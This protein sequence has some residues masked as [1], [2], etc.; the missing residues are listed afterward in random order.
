M[1]KYKINS[2]PDLANHKR[3]RT[4][5]KKLVEANNQIEKLK[6]ELQLVKKSKRKTEEGQVRGQGTERECF[7]TA[8]RDSKS[9]NK[10]LNKYDSEHAKDSNMVSIG[11]CKC[12][13]T[14]K[15][16]VQRN[17]R[18]EEEN[19]DPSFNIN[20]KHSLDPLTNEE[21][22]ISAKVEH[23]E[24]LPE[25]K[26]L[27][28]E[29]AFDMVVKKL[30][31]L[32]RQ[33]FFESTSQ[34]SKA[35]TYYDRTEEI[36]VILQ[37][38]ESKEKY[39]GHRTFKPAFSTLKEKSDMISTASEI[40]NAPKTETRESTGE[41]QGIK[42]TNSTDQE[43][44]K[45]VCNG[46]MVSSHGAS[47]DFEKHYSSKDFSSKEFTEDS[48]ETEKYIPGSKFY[49]KIDLPKK[50]EIRR[51]TEWD[52]HN[53]ND[54][55]NSIK[56]I[57]ESTRI[58][59][60]CSHPDKDSIILQEEK[61][62]KITDT[63]DPFDNLRPE[64]FSKHQ[65][66]CNFL[67]G[68]G[69]EKQYS[70]KDY[71]ATELI[72]NDTL[73]TKKY[74]PAT[75]FYSRTDTPKKRENRRKT[76]LDSSDLNDLK[77]LIKDISESISMSE[78][79]DRVIDTDYPVHKL[80]SE[81]S[82]HQDSHNLIEDPIPQ[83]DETADLSCDDLISR[84]LSELQTTRSPEQFPADIEEKE[85][86][87]ES[88][89]EGLT[90]KLSGIRQKERNAQELSG[91]VP[92][93]KFYSR[94]D[95]PKK[96]EVRRKTEL[97]SQVL[98]NLK[99]FKN[100]AESTGISE[101]YSHPHEDSI[102]SQEQ[103]GSIVEENL[104]Y[105]FDSLVSE[106]LS[107]QLQDSYDLLEDPNNQQDENA[108]KSAD[109]SWDDLIS[110]TLSE[111]QTTL[112]PEQVSICAKEKTIPKAIT[113]ERVD[114]GK[115]ATSSRIKLEEGKGQIKSD[116]VVIYPKRSRKQKTIPIR[117]I[118]TKSGN[119]EKAM[120]GPSEEYSKKMEAYHALDKD[121]KDEFKNKNM[122]DQEKFQLS[123]KDTSSFDLEDHINDGKICK[124]GSRTEHMKNIYDKKLLAEKLRDGT[125]EIM[126]TTSNT[127]HDNRDDEL[128][129]QEW[130]QLGV[131][132]SVSWDNSDNNAQSYEKGSSASGER[133]YEEP[134]EDEWNYSDE[135]NEIDLNTG[136]LKHHSERNSS[137]PSEIAIKNKNGQGQRNGKTHKT[138]QTRKQSSTSSGEIPRESNAKSKE[139][140]YSIENGEHVE[141]LSEKSVEDF[142]HA[143]W[144]RDS[145]DRDHLFS[146]LMT[147]NDGQ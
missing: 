86:S 8:K 45:M 25:I 43:T 87:S 120:K 124:N 35:S 139:K 91:Y 23:Y 81:V 46:Q 101:K 85:I 13:K 31:P 107:K 74:I 20:S 129:A 133:V 48:L 32:I 134:V 75:K 104:D 26:D 22:E 98:N 30:I 140:R 19:R 102:I 114:G 106:T 122:T 72:D 132:P 144:S 61:K 59:E 56:N 5:T 84:S 108:E 111:L 131:I 40:D 34:L 145:L 73:E 137:G 83:E 49:S 7:T 118:D 123:S 125:E 17:E 1:Y 105:P 147:K 119:T 138:K 27:Q 78:K 36:S 69:V 12:S 24:E 55:K 41:E 113:A 112:S 10:K 121:S 80:G 146:I 93:S 128:S 76:E 71:S 103:N 50:K 62:D 67:D 99:D 79:Q 54:L 117:K 89:R 39:A 42:E 11:T 65:D 33:E 15:S 96:R 126:S 90:S 38:P 100:I 68:S 110:R 9:S 52:P 44:G 77:N 47:S 142:T 141:E 6:R 116:S 109:S 127:H 53:L 29:K 14:Y 70:S 136:T 92:G 94:I 18:V 21:I 3:E 82:K 60:E 95:L 97:D 28:N 63:D 64:T 51:K 58:S 130:Q 66:S 115:K 4:L 37:D 57:A 135:A 16:S 143:N 88:G 2:L